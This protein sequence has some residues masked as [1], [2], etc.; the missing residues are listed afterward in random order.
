MGIQF[1]YIRPVG[2]IASD[3]QEKDLF[4]GV[5]LVMYSPLFL[6]DFTLLFLVSLLLLT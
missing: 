1:L 2:R 6:V 5:S 3:E 4:H